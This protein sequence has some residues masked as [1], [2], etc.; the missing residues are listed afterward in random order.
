MVLGIVLMVVNFMCGVVNLSITVALWKNGGM[1][2]YASFSGAVVG[3]GAVT[4]I[5][6]RICEAYL[7]GLTGGTGTMFLFSHFIHL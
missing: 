3:F 7:T 6:Y 1:L 5:G 4:G 2:R